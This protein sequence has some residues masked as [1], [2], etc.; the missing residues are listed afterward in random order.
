MIF[1]D[2]PQT[3]F[4]RCLLY[5]NG[6]SEEDFGVYNPR[7]YIVGEGFDSGWE[8]CKNVYQN[9]VSCRN[10]EKRGV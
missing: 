2:R 6:V 1:S 7:K 10:S 4:L 9:K 3:A 5:E 8:N